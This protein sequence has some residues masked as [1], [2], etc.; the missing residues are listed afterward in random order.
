[1]RAQALFLSIALNVLLVV[2]LSFQLR[3]SNT[4]RVLFGSC[5]AFVR[6]LGGDG[7][8]PFFRVTRAGTLHG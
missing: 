8:G 1:M 5:G 7:C 2:T 4:G 6:M 3:S